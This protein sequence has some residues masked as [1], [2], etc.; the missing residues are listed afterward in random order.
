MKERPQLPANHQ[1]PGERPGALCP[2]TPPSLKENQPCQ[3][4]DPLLP[5]SRAG[6]EHFS[7]GEALGV[8]CRVTA[9]LGK[10]HTVTLTSPTP[11]GFLIHVPQRTLL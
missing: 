7:V 6:R 1:E 2:P 11:V 4:F 10:T 3:P 8:R 5:A 9:V